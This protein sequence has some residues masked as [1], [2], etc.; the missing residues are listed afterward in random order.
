MEKADNSG[1]TGK[2]GK[3]DVG[4]KKDKVGKA[5]A[6]IAGNVGKAVKAGKKGNCNNTIQINIKTMKFITGP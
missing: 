6:D 5:E 2:V 1:Q 3:E 4:G